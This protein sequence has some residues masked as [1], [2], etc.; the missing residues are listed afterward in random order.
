MFLTSLR[1]TTFLTTQ[2]INA[3]SSYFYVVPKREKCGRNSV[4]IIYL[5]EK[6]SARKN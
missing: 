5:I 3:R 6:K 2:I 4:A 1:K